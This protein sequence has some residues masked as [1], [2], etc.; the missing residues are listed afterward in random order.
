MTTALETHFL[1]VTSEEIENITN[2]CERWETDPELDHQPKFSWTSTYSNLEGIP[3]AFYPGNVPAAYQY[4]Y[5]IDLDR[6]LFSIND[7]VAFD[8]WAIPAVERVAKAFDGG[9][10]DPVNCPEGS[11]R[12]EPPGYFQDVDDGRSVCTATYQQY[13]VIRVEPI[14]SSEPL[15]KAP[16]RRIFARIVFD[17][18][19][20][21]GPIYMGHLSGMAHDSFAF[22]EVAFAILSLA[23]GNFYFDRRESFADQDQDR[24]IFRV[25]FPD[26]GAPELMPIFGSGC[27][28]EHQEPGSSP[29]G[30]MYWFEGALISLVSN[31]VFDGDADT[32]AAIGKAV[33]HALES[34]KLDFQIVLFSIQSAILVEVQSRSATKTI[35][36]SGVISI[37]DLKQSWEIKLSGSVATGTDPYLCSALELLQQIHPGF[38]ILETFMDVARNRESRRELSGFG[39]GC[40]PMEIYPEIIK[41]C[42]PQTHRA[43]AKV[44]PLFRALCHKNFPF[45]PGLMAVRLEDSG[46]PLLKRKNMLNFSGD[47]GIFTC[48]DKRSGLILQSTLDTDLRN[49]IHEREWVSTFFPVFGE[50]ARPSMMTQVPL[51]ILL[52]HN[53]QIWDDDIVVIGGRHI[54]VLD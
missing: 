53:N 15:H 31:E 21:P 40:F 16:L 14:Q 5:L 52:H 17:K 36:R 4:I 1:V 7:C 11:S 33:A 10:F 19:M 34:G 32:E 30:S 44:S 46:R 48:H 20:R 38:T 45:S 9:D 3:T 54:S 23:T 28:A 43:C 26:E 49:R 12:V 18:L 41:H 42:D 8:L 25:S 47:I 13:S 24:E 35:R 50:S 37:F 29:P 51:H 39:I 2:S 6:E 27:H 22:R